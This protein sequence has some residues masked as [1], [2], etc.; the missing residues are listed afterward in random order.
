MDH[1]P[2]MCGGLRMEGLTLLDAGATISNM[3]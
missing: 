2:H 1:A 3:A